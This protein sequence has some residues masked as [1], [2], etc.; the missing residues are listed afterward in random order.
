VE[1][2]ISNTVNSPTDVKFFVF[3]TQHINERYKD[4]IG[5][6]QGYFYNHLALGATLVALYTWASSSG[7]QPCGKSTK[8]DGCDQV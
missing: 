7:E 2:V 4:I 8:A 6:K 3:A 5:E 1:T